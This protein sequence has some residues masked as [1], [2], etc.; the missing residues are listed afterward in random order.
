M[1]PLVGLDH[2]A[3]DLHQGRFAGAVFADEADD[4]ARA[5]L[6]AEVGQRHDAGIGLAHA[7]QL[8]ERLDR[9]CG[10]G[11]RRLFSHAVT[12]RCQQR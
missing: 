12:S 2:A 8:Q 7:S 10:D 11:R 3:E 9:G 1:V 4:L 6:H 5:D